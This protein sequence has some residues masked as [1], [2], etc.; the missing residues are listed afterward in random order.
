MPE[1]ST[2]RSKLRSDLVPGLV[3]AGV[4][5]VLFWPL[6]A[7]MTSQTFQHEQ[8]KN[9]LVICLASI[10]AC[11]WQ[12]GERLSTTWTLSNTAI[13]LVGLALV[14]VA[15]AGYLNHPEFVI[16]GLLCALAG[17]A[18][19][20][21]GASARVLLKPALAGLTGFLALLFLMP[22]LDWP[23]RSLAGV[24]AADILIRMGLTS[25][26]SLLKDQAGEWQLVLKLGKNAFIVAPEC[27]GF[28]LISSCLLLALILSQGSREPLWWKVLS[29]PVAVFTA[30]LFNL[31]RI[32]AITLLAQKFPGREAYDFIH[33]TA[34]IVAL[35]SGLA[36]VWWLSGF[37]L[38]LP[39][40]EPKT[41]TSDTP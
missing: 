12:A 39:A 9:A 3:L 28:G 35:W 34:G 5:L 23:L 25:E 17:I 33:E 1:P 29:L 40:S 38:R 24:H 8:L 2:L 18:Q 11:V 31:A 13:C 16:I 36:A 20:V 21:W 15:G 14:L 4:C 19:F 6:L 32:L 41:S 7:W 26:L 30:F 27:N 37:R 10:V 22:Y